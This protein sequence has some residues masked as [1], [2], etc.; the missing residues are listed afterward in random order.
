VAFGGESIQTAA[1]VVPHIPL[2]MPFRILFASDEP[3]Q[4]RKMA[5][6][7][8][9]AKEIHSLGHE[10]AFK[11]K[12]PPLLHQTFGRKIFNG[13][14]SADFDGGRIRIEPESGNELHSPQ[15]A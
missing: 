14:S 6:P 4:L 12:L 7:A 8:S 5:H 15:N 2:R 3:V 11:K 9:A 1:G 10:Y 13:H